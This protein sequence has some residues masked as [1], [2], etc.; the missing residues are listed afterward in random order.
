MSLDFPYPGD[1]PYDLIRVSCAFDSQKTTVDTVVKTV[2]EAS[3]SM[4]GN[5]KAEAATAA[6]ADLSRMKT[7][8]SKVSADF[9]AA[10]TAID[11]LRSTLTSIRLEVDGLRSALTKANLAMTSEQHEMGISG[12]VQGNDLTAAQL[13]SYRASIT[14][15]EGTTQRTINNLGDQYDALVRKANSATA[16]C[17]HALTSTVTA[18]AYEGSTYST[19]GLNQLLGLD[20]LSLLCAY[21]AKLAASPPNFPAHATPAQIRAWWAALPPEAR[22]DYEADWPAVV[23]NTNGIPLP[24]RATANHGRAEAD[25][26]TAQLNGDTAKV[27]LLKSLLEPGS[28]LVMYDT[29]QD[30]YGV[31][32]GNIDASHVALFVPGVG[33]DGNIHGWVGDA[34]NIQQTAGPDSA[35]IMWKGYDDPGDHGTLDIANAGFTARAEAGATNLTAFATGGLQLGSNQSLTIVAHS[36]G[37]VV[38][39]VALSEDGL[40][41]TDVVTAGSPGMTVDDVGQ[42]HLKSNQFYAEQAPQ[43]PVA[44]NLSGLGNDPTSP[45]FGGTRLATNG[46]GLPNVTGHSMYFDPG[47]EA[48]QGIASVVDGDV[49]H[50]DVQNP[51]AGDDAGAIARI[52]VNPAGPLLDDAA[53][54]YHGPGSSAVSAVAHLNNVIAGNVDVGVRDGTNAVE[55]G[56]K[57]VWGWVS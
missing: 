41:P 48:I 4:T 23:G 50:S 14:A 44:N 10:S 12:R 38:T 11:T 56:V 25:L 51:S 7:V 49:P 31:L 54:D 55:S 40:K 47:T 21:D 33:N 17:S 15:D 39:G 26:A 46:A 37:S 1:D 6:A 8:L 27:K 5:W 36:Y 43:D 16:T 18:H 52:V 45:D 35:V 13:N 9:A 32:W 42:L 22:A 24:D 30:H 3:S 57:K 28:S 53:R 29:S 34:H 19:V 20:G 2:G